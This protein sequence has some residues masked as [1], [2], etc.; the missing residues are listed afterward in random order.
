[1][2]AAGF[3]EQR[4]RDSFDD[5]LMV[6]LDGRSYSYGLYWANAQAIAAAWQRAGVPRGAAVALVLPN[7]SSVLACYL[8]CAIGGYVACP[9]IPMHVPELID[10]ML[11]LVRPGLGVRRPPVLDPGLRPPKPAEI[12]VALAS[13]EH[14]AVV[15]T[16]GTTSLPKGICHSL[17]AM[18]DSARAFGELSGMH[19]GTRL[20]HVLPMAYMAGLLNTMLAPLCVG[21]TIIEG[22]AISAATAMD[23]WTRPLAERANFLTLVP[24]AAAVLAKLSRD[25]TVAREAAA[26]LEQIQCTAGQLQ[27]AVR[28]QFLEEFGR[29][30]QDCYGLTELG[31]PLT[32][33]TPDDARVEENV[34]YPV[35]GLDLDLRPSSYGDPELWIRSPFA[36]EGYLTD[37]GIETPFDEDGFMATGD[38]ARIEAGKVHITGRIK[39]CIVRGGINVA[40]IL[41]ENQLGR[42]EGVEHV[43]VVGV[44]D[45]F[46]GEII[47]ACVIPAAGSDPQDVKR[48]VFQ[49][50]GKILDANL[51]PDRVVTM[52]SF[53]RASTGKVQKFSLRSALTGAPPSKAVLP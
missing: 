39:D 27:S 30:L 2:D 47:V 11:V 48:S 15:L 38:L 28:R 17:Q 9:I 36:M 34:G 3:L 31:G 1:M 44:P 33:Q 8:A 10:A 16:S 13:Q 41:I 37:G 42:V 52:E 18:I 50:A 22:P 29:P 43:A 21:G 32:T 35:A 5:T 25:A 40:P 46:W 6:A 4:F 49:F 53:P 20:Y 51:R 7:S 23:F 14:F 19:R 45:D 24:T 26:G 12:R